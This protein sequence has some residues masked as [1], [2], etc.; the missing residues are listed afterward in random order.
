VRPSLVTIQRRGFEPHACIVTLDACGSTLQR[1]PARFQDDIETIQRCVIEAHGCAFAIHRCTAIAL[2]C[3][4]T[5][6]AP[7][8]TLRGIIVKVQAPIVKVQTIHVK[9]V[10]PIDSVQPTTCIAH[11]TPSNRRSRFLRGQGRAQA[12]RPHGQLAHVGG[13]PSTS[14]GGALQISAE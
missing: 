1:I 7:I 9:V 2:G 13:E 8:A 3:E 11:P 5:L 14:L 10:E 4:T 6:Q 12:R